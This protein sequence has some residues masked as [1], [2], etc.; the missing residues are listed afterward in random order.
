MVAVRA[1]EFDWRKIRM[2]RESFNLSVLPIIFIKPEN[3]NVI[4]DFSEWN[5]K[6]LEIENHNFLNF[7]PHFGWKNYIEYKK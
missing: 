5:S 4:S 2:I 7:K 3:I 6:F 1:M